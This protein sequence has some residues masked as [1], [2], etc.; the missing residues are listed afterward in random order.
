MN[1]STEQKIMD[2]DHGEG[3]GVGWTGSLGLTDANYCF[4]NGLTMRSY[5]VALR[6]MSRYLKWS[7]TMGEK[8]LYT[9]MCNWVPMLYSWKKICWGNKKIKNEIILQEMQNNLC[10]RERI[11]VH[12]RTDGRR[13]GRAGGQKSGKLMILMAVVVISWVYIYVKIGQMVFF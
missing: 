13:A 5:S 8:S 10:D 3:E 11:V 1:L 7:T 4:W 6:T 9:C 2:L 12:L